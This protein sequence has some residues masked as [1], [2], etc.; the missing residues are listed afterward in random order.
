[1][2]VFENYVMKQHSNMKVGGVAKKFIVV[3]DKNELKG[4]I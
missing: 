1:M 4:I 2:K 3:E